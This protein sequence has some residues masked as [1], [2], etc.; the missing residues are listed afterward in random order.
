MRSIEIAMKREPAIYT[1][2]VDYGDYDLV[3]Q[4]KWYVAR[5]HKG[6]VYAQRLIARSGG[7]TTQK[8]HSLITGYPRTDHINHNGLDNRRANLRSVTRS[9]NAMNSRPQA[10]FASA[11][12][13]VGWDKKNNRWLARITVNRK[14]TYLGM[15]KTE[16][17][18]ARAYD[19]AARQMHGE[20]AWTNQDCGLL[21][22]LTD[23]LE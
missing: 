23:G 16:I 18:A 22:S 3:M 20:F 7:W 2:L 14:T 5:D 4:Y 15:F 17:E 1:A 21:T 6:I 12:K 19:L 8:M 9:Q 10:G 13:G 11:Y